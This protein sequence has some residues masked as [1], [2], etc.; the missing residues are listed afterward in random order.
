MNREQARDVIY[1][2][3]MAAWSAAVAYAGVPAQAP[4]H[5]RWQGVDQAEP[6]QGSYWMRTTLQTVDEDQETLR[7][8]DVRRF[9]TIGNVFVQIFVP[10]TDDA[11]G[12]RLDKLAE[13]LRN[14]FR[15]RQA[16]ANV[17]FTSAK[18][19]DNVR[20]E[21]AWLSVLVTCRFSYRQFV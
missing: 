1:S 12:Q 9:N 16:D 20:R 10:N 19:D 7:N 15:D 17:E 18:I 21:P 6:P 14:A 11:A 8:G 2:H 4:K 5:T 3:A 13:S